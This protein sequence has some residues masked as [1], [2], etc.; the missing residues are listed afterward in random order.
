MS[1]VKYEP[2]EIK[3]VVS[4]CSNIILNLSSNE[5]NIAKLLKEI[6]IT[7]VIEILEVSGTTFETKLLTSC[8]LCW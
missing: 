6:D 8:A 1:Q 7:R 3:E 4:S 2:K 5:E